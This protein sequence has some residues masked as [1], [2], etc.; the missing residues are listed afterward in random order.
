[1]GIPTKNAEVVPLWKFAGYGGPLAMKETPMDVVTVHLTREQRD[2]LSDVAWQELLH[3]QR[4]IKEGD[5]TAKT[6]ERLWA[7]I[8]AALMPQT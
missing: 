4:Q 3:A 7:A 1:M 5:A 8:Y 6:R 2:A